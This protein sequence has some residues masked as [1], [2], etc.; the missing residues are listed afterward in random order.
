MLYTFW[1]YLDEMYTFCYMKNVCVCG[2]N[3]LV[4]MCAYSKANVAAVC[5]KNIGVET[6]ITICL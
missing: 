2:A 1:K 3:V 5:L 6:V 4:D